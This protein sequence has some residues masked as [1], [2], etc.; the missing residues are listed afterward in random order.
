MSNVIDFN[1]ERAVRKSGLH[2]TACKQMIEDGFN[3]LVP[4][5]IESYGDWFSVSGEFYQ[6]H[7][8]TD[9]AIQRLLTEVLA[10]DPE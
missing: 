6:E 8:W 9:E 4:N 5:D 7:N 1:L 2:R 10:Q 3:P